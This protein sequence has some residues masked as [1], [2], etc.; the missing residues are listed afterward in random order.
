MFLRIKLGCMCRYSRDSPWSS[1]I[2]LC[3]WNVSMW[4]QR[5]CV[6]L[7][8]FSNLISH[9][10]QLSPLTLEVVGAPQMTLQQSFQPFPV[11]RCPHGIS[12]PHSRPFL[13]VI[14]PSLLLSSSPSCSF[15]WP[16]RTVF[17]MPEDMWPYH[18]SFRVL[19]MVRRSLCTPTAFWILLRT[20][21]FVTWSL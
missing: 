6:I 2:W 3:P 17:T 8:L 9:L 18:L 19:T 21:S 16:C 11:F 20:S 14:F 7:D 15:Y 10:S 12:K 4:F 13:D 1:C 5:L